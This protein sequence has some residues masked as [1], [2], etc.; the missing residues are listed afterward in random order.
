MALHAM[1]VPRTLRTALGMPWWLIQLA[2]GAKSFVDNPLIGSR[3]LNRAGLHGARKRIAER[4]ADARR[5]RLARGAAK[6]MPA[7]VRDAFDRQGYV[8]VEGLMP[9]ADFA[10]LRRAILDHAAPA[11]EMLQGDTI[12]R[13]IAIDPAYLSA[14]PRLAALLA[15]PEWRALMRYAASFDSEPLYYIQTILSHVVD[16]PPDP[17]TNLHADTF[18]PT[19]KAWFFLND[20]PGDE[21]PF[22][23]VPGSHRATPERLAWEQARALSLPD[24]A[25]RLSSRGSMR[26]RADELAGIGLPPP[27]AL[28]VP[29]NTLVVA[30]TGGFHARGPSLRQSS[31]VEIWAYSRRNPFLPWAGLDPLSLPGIAERRIGAL[32]AARDALERWVGQPW[33]PVGLKRPLDR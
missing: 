19:M 15:H 6:A 17:Q 12:T 2:T 7:P 22:T 27:V 29:A 32:W 4:I 30:D 5:R 23:Y 26:V 25:D 24:A 11:R 16:A 28:A 13:R 9:A 3:R 21:G 14:V 8:A 20:V 1:D 18:H 31:R 33:Q 10:E